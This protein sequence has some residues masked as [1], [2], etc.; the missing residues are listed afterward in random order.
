[1]VFTGIV[2][3]DVSDATIADNSIAIDGGMDVAGVSLRC[4]NL[5]VTAGVNHNEII[6]YDAATKQ[7]GVRITC[8][9]D[10]GDFTI[11]RN[12]M[13]FT[14]PSNV[15][16][17]IR[18]IDATSLLRTIT[19]QAINNVILM[20]AAAI[21]D[22]ATKTAIYLKSLSATSTVSAFYNT[23]L[24]TGNNG[25]MHG[26]YSSQT[27]LP[28]NATGNIFL[29][30]GKNVNNAAFSLPKMCAANFCA[31]DIVTNLFNSKFFMTDVKLIYY[32]DTNESQDLSI[33]NECDAVPAPADCTNGNVN[34]T[35]NVVDPKVKPSYFDFVTGELLL[36]NQVLVKDQGQPVSTVIDDINGKVRDVTPDIGATEY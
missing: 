12:T 24:I 30:Y 6:F 20:P 31:K 36:A 1:V 8:T 33:V 11:E 4:Q 10:N 18:G 9:Q 29:M 2:I 21:G 27:N 13:S 22:A 16:V 32:Y 28:L 19:L 15:G 35:G 34:Y 5:P 25:E 23:M 17:E 26:V 14:P 3:S 7:S